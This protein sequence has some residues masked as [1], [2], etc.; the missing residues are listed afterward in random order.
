VRIQYKN[1]VE[2]AKLHLTKITVILFW[3]YVNRWFKRTLCFTESFLSKL[4]KVLN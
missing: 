1:F 4:H 2:E 3:L